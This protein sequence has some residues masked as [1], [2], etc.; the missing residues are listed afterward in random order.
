MDEAGTIHYS[1]RW[2]RALSGHDPAETAPLQLDKLL[3]VAS[4]VFYQTHMLPLLKIRGE[5]EELYLTLRGAEGKPVPVLASGRRVAGGNEARYVWVF[6][7]IPQRSKFENELLEAKKAADVA[8]L[9]KDE[10]L[11]HVSHELRTPLG[12]IMGWAQLLRSAEGDAESLHHGLDIIERNARS[13]AKLIEDILDSTRI[14]GGKLHLHP[15]PVDLVPVLEAALEIIRP[16]A[17]AKSITL[18]LLPAAFPTVVLGDVERLQQIFWNLLGNAVKFTGS[19]GTIKVWFR[20]VNS[21][22][23]VAITDSGQGISPE[24]LP[25]VFVRFRQSGDAGSRKAGLGLGTSITR[26]LVELHGGVIRAESAG[27]GLGSTFCVRLP[28]VNLASAEATPVL[29]LG[30]I[31]LQGL[32]LLLV[33]DDPDARHMLHTLLSRHGS[34][35]AAVGSAAEALDWLNNHPCDLMISDIDMPGGDGYGLMR[36]VR[37]SP[38]PLLRRLPAVALTANARFADRMNTLAAG[39]QM[40]ISKP[41]HPNELLATVANL[42]MTS[43]EGTTTGTSAV[44]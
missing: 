44:D 2:L 23:E 25:F 32:R 31:S 29:S 16:A 19:G 36:Q 5:A 1:N 28:I 27:L 3:T 43:A 17:S 18:S 30:H 41:V 9:E 13:Q 37:A 34:R 10:F 11:A 40:H 42:M 26:D 24:F 15:A 22:V 35:A 21:S 8:G 4:R 39:F 7:H 12:S 33:D 14:R 20:E 38:S 6:T